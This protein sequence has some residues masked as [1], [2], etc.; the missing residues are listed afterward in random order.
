MERQRSSFK[1]PILRIFVLALILSSA[2]AFKSTNK[3]AA[4]QPVQKK[5]E[6][7]LIIKDI[8]FELGK[9]GKEIV[10]IYSNQYFEP[11][12]FSLDGKKPRLV[13]DIKNLTTYKK[14]PSKIVANGT[15]IK[16]IRTYFNPKSKTLRVV[17]DHYPSMSYIV[18][19]IFFEAEN[20][21]VV[22]VEK[23]QEGKEQ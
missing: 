12:V 9:G 23:Q 16:Q 5:E 2:F 4:V 15:L 8:T 7:P 19:Q 20:V 13:V 11:M 1:G 17:L 18:T 22:M 21:Y 10:L 3:A 6:V 14:G